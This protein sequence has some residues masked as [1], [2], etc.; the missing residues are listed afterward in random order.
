MKALRFLR[1]IIVDVG[2]VGLKFYLEIPWAI[3]KAFREKEEFC[4][5]CKL[6]YTKEIPKEKH[7]HRPLNER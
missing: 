6:R 1:F 3:W 4:S 7:D 2:W 5:N